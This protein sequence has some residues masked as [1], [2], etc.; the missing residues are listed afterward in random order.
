MGGWTCLS[1]DGHTQWRI[2]VSDQSLYLPAGIDASQVGQGS[3]GQQY[4]LD[5]WVTRTVAGADTRPDTPG[6]RPHQASLT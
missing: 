3:K 4:K 2:Q 1:Q 5:H 6:N